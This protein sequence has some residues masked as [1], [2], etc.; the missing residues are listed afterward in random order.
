ML[1]H[2]VW[3][4]TVVAVTDPATH[5]LRTL[6]GSE[7]SREFGI[8]VGD[9][10]V[11]YNKRVT[12]LDRLANTVVIPPGEKM[13][14]KFFPFKCSIGHDA[15][16][17]S[18][19]GKRSRCAA[20][21]QAEASYVPYTTPAA[22][23]SDARTHCASSHGDDRSE[24]GSPRRVATDDDVSVDMDTNEGEGAHAL[25]HARQSNPISAVDSMEGV[26]ESPPRVTE[27]PPR[28]LLRILGVSAGIRDI[29]D[30]LLK[31][32]PIYTCIYANQSGGEITDRLTAPQICTS[33]QNAEVLA[34]FRSSRSTTTLERRMDCKQT[35]F[36]SK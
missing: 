29:N 1:T 28:V 14:C 20:A 22:Q 15:E 25:G 11:F 21:S 5:E 6:A 7:C 27:V 2:C 26:E 10:L 18:A 34:R 36:V 33:K 17:A 3:P 24:P 23:G 35:S 4:E 8:D 13:L 32:L 16:K 19:S 31:Q 30:G 9:A 12:T